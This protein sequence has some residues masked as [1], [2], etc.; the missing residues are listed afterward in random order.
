MPCKTLHIEGMYMFAAIRRV[1]AP[2]FLLL[3]FAMPAAASPLAQVETPYVV[4]EIFT[5]PAAAKDADTF[6]L[7]VR[8]T[9][10]EGWHTYWKNY[11]DTGKAPQFDW[12]LPQGWDIAP[13]LYP[14]PERIPVGFLMNY[15]YEHPNTLLFEV[16]LPDT[17][18]LPADIALDARWLICEEVCVP[19]SASFAFTIAGDSGQ[20]E[21]TRNV[22]LA[23]RDALPEP[24]PFAVTAEASDAAFALSVAMTADEAALVRDA[25]YFPEEKDL[26]DYQVG[27]V[28]E[29]SEGWLRL[30][31]GRPGAAGSYD[32]TSG[33][34]V[35]ENAAGLR[36]GFALRAAIQP[37]ET[38]AAPAGGDGGGGTLA[39][40]QDGAGVGAGANNAISLFQAFLFA[41]L[42]GMI[43]NLM[44][45][46]FPVLSLKAFSL[47]R[48]HGAGEAAARQD[49]LAYAAG[50]LVSFAVVAGVFLAL[51]SAGAQI[52][53][54]FQLQSPLVVGALA[55]LLFL[56]GLNLIG[57]YDLSAGRLSGVGQGLAE[58]G[59]RSGAFF[60]GVLAT[61]V[62]TPCT[63]PFMAP[64]LGFALFQP[65]PVAVGIFLSLGLGLAL[66]YLLIAY[67]PP[68][69]RVLPKPG[70]WM[71]TFRQFLAFPM[72][73]AAIWLVWV[74]AQQ[75]G[76][77]AVAGVL[78]A[79]LVAAFAIWLV[80]KLRGQGGLAAPAVGLGAGLA[81][82]LAVLGLPGGLSVSGSS[83]NSAMTASGGDSAGFEQALGVAPWSRDRVAELRAEGRPVFAYFTAAWCITCKVNERV[84]LAADSVREAVKTSG[85][86]VLK[87]DWTNQNADIAQELERFGRSGV[88]MYVLYPAD[89]SAPRLLPEVLTPDI[90]TGAFADAAAERQAT[91]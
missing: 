37:N 43:L 88:P 90:L 57:V 53:W 29:A 55:L 41:L 46:V 84:A 87:A 50:I 60:T 26:I 78:A 85:V 25:Y 38:L 71:E 59:G 40:L 34:L 23:A 42:G 19:E 11:G 76:A 6:W 67:I 58:R 86:A 3:A 22:F 13:P 56:V 12:R 52:G 39:A 69:R 75:G 44:P 5:E 48:S 24:I 32:S 10:D 45:C 74:L 63:A 70:P 16:S 31:T 20:D 1:C 28:R 61:V 66:P 33:I 21:A 79:M 80:R 35:V 15:G 77:E 54:G 65:A 51:K 49:G 89:G 72:F 30:I 91:G 82:M 47:I 18:A 68:L 14:V 7:A 64:A 4:V 36:E 62:A 73:L 81:L 8:F 17:A 83:S 9:P 27:Q 2:V